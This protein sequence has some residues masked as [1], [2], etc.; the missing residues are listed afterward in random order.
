LLSIVMAAAGLRV[1]W[2]LAGR[3]NLWAGLEQRERSIDTEYGYKDIVPPDRGLSINFNSSDVGAFTLSDITDY[4][5][6]VRKKVQRVLPLPELTEQ[7]VQRI[8]DVTQGVPLAVK[9]AAGLYLETADLDS[10]TEKVEGKRE[11][12]DQ[13]VRRYLLHA[14]DNQEERATLYALALLRRAD[15]PA[16]VAAALGLIPEDA[17]TSYAGTLSRLH[18]RYSFIFTEKDEPALHQEVR[19][20]LRLWLREHCKQP[21]IIAINERLKAAHEAEL[22]PLEEQRMY[23][24]LKDRLQDEEWT[25]VYLDL[26]EQQFWLDPVEGVHY[27]LPFMISAAIYNRKMNKDAAE[28]GTFF[29]RNIGMPYRNWLRWAVLSLRFLNNRKCS[30]EVLV[31]LEKLAD[32]VESRRCSSFPL[33][34]PNCKDELEAAL[35]WRLGEAYLDRDGSK[36][37]GWY[38]KC[39]E[40]LNN[41]A[42][43]KEDTARAYG[44]VAEKLSDEKKYAECITLLNRAIELKPDNAPTYS[45]RGFAHGLLKEYRH[46]LDDFTRA[47]EFDPN[48]A[49]AYYNR[50]TAYL[51]LKDVSQAIT[52]YTRSQ[53]LDP[54]DIDAAWMAEWVGMGKQ[55]MSID[56]AERLEKIAVISPQHYRAYVCRGIA[57]ALRS[58]L[59]EGLAELELAFPLEPEEPDAYFWKGMLCAYYYKGRYQLAMDAIGKALEVELPPVLLTLLYWLEKDRP[60]FFEQYARPLLDK[61]GV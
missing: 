2:V 1:G 33:S 27:V 60:D 37:L 53:E 29:A 9:I 18:R 21:E 34:L 28:V 14:R 30:D 56:V 15:H 23:G 40:R 41:E 38:E 20:F 3:D 10:I 43:L 25:G 31:G 51:Y 19:H 24:T 8:L 39:L 55:R 16:A 4:F 46:A 48:D 49:L 54:T 57:L 50:G 52:D 26:T 36:A 59:K 5:A 58:R 44:E 22:K 45:N 61:Y 17:K 6:L 12:I 47:L 7:D 35:W 42:I 13:M 11:I 32:L